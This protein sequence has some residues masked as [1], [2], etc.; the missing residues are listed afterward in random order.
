L[1]E[2][3]SAAA[4]FDKLS[5][6]AP[7]DLSSIALLLDVDGTLLDTAPTPKSVVVPD[8]LRLSLERL[9]VLTGGAVAF[10]SGRLISDLD[11]L[12]VPLRLPAIGGHGAQI[13]FA[14]N[15]RARE[16]HAEVI[17]E[18]CR[19]LVAATAAVDPRI[20]VENKGS[21]LAVHYRLA[22]DFE[23]M[24]RTKLAAIVARMDGLDLIHGKAVIEIKSAH[25][26]K[27][28]AVQELMLNPPFSS[29]KP[30]FIGDDTT[31]ESVFAVLPTLR[32]VGYSVERFMVGASGM[33]G[34]PRDVREWLAGLCA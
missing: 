13:R 17:G 18:E 32:G 33:F 34:A 29:R 6:P 24:L 5:Q 8:S 19:R 3:H 23:K 16:R 10:V 12:F 14:G 4:Q 1:S 15:G 9:A 20:V 2:H 28:T 7:P 21:S 30:I 11:T 26:S 27:G 22:P 31:D 25:F